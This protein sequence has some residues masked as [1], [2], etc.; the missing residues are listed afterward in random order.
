[1]KNLIIFLII[2]IF[3]VGCGKKSEPKYQG[4]KNQ[5]EKKVSLNE[6]ILL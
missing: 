6:Q 3:F 1:L 5:Y 4:K 2:S